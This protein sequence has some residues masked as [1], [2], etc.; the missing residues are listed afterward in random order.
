MLRQR[1][2]S[3]HVTSQQQQQHRSA[4]GTVMASTAAAA[5]E[6]VEP[7]PIDRIR[8][9]MESGIRGRRGPSPPAPPPSAASAPATAE[10][11]VLSTGAPYDAVGGV[12]G[13]QKQRGSSCQQKSSSQK[14][15]Q[16]QKHYQSEHQLHATTPVHSLQCSA[17]AG[18]SS[19]EPS[20]ERRASSIH[21]VR[22]SSSF[23]LGL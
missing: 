20:R 13:H 7:K 18:P 2:H 17:S 12:A 5:V 19:R 6:A 4:S 16:Q 15:Q 11:D 14:Q 9:S 3:L 1:Q 21:E 22:S 10:P 8:Y 23:A